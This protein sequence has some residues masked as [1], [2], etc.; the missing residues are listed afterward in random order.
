MRVDPYKMRP[1]PPRVAVLTSAYAALVEGLGELGLDELPPD[2]RVFSSGELVSELLADELGEA[3]TWNGEP[4]R[5]RPRRMPGPWKN[6]TSDVR[7]FWLPFPAPHVALREFG[8]WRDWL[9]AHGAAPLGS[10]GSSG[11]SL[12]RATLRASLWT[13]VGDRPPVRF[14]LGGRQE[15]GGRGC[16]SFSGLLEHWDLPA[17]YAETLGSLRY[18]GWWRRVDPRFPFELAH[19]RGML[20]FVRARVKVPEMRLGPLPRRP[21]EQP[22]VWESVL[23]PIEYPV[24]RRLQGCWTWDELAGAIAVGARIEKVFDV[25]IHVAPEDE[26]PFA[27][28]WAAV[29]GGRAM[30]GFAGMLAKASG[31]ALWGQFAIRPD[32]RRDVVYWRRRGGRMTKE[33]RQ[34]RVHGTRPGAPDLAELITG[35]VRARLFAMMHATGDRFISAHTDGVWTRELDFR[36][37]GWR[38]DERASRLDVLG[39]QTIRYWPIGQQEPSYI[40]SGVPERLAAEAFARAWASAEQESTLA[41]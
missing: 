7:V 20:V 15:L 2:V 30:S 5:W 17:A 24:G 27:P 39:P 21:R 37:E 19:E 22:H 26:L 36:P 35:K 32:G 1:V 11:Y 6:S 14:T 18:G 41:A 9:G 38:L 31:N 29:Q 23:F 10:L 28:W 34:Q 40:V 16:G 25:W 3:L 4:I 13:S 8:L 12:L 33:V